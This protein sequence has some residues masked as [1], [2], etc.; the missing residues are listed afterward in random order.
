[1]DAAPPSGPG[2]QGS[3]YREIADTLMHE[4]QGGTW[5]AGSQL[6]AESDL[7]RRFGASRNTV[8]ESLRQLDRQ[9]YI[10][11]QRGSR[12]VVVSNT[13]I[14]SFVNSIESIDDIMRYSSRTEPRIVATD[15]IVT[16]ADMAAEIG[17]EP[18]SQWLRVQLLRISMPDGK[19]VGYSSIYI[20]PRY[21]AICERLAESTPLYRMLAEQFGLEYVRA[22]QMIEAQA[23]T[24]SI[25]GLLGLAEGSAIMRVRTEF[26]TEGEDVVEIAFGHFPASGYRMEIA[27]KRCEN[28]AGA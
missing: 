15:M 28:T 24:S 14:E 13:P 18:G 6:P 22:E 26:V 5:I 21:A 25:A 9:G 1:M 27:L 20:D 12:S 10:R 19:A 7:A 16:D 4:I 11:R 8:R 23:A 17:V 3:G 2:A